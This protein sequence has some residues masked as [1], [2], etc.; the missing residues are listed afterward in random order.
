M[1]VS[2]DGPRDG[3]ATSILKPKTGR[4]QMEGEKEGPTADYN[5][6]KT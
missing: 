6:K 3:G 5:N 1:N 4:R 2:E